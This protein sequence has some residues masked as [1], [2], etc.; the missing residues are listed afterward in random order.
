MKI[1]IPNL[2]RMFNDVL[3]FVKE[4][5]G[6]K[7]Y[8]D[9]QDE[10]ADGIKCFVF[11]DVSSQGEE[12]IVYGVR[13]AQTNGADDLQICYEPFVRTYRVE[14]AED[15]FKTADW[16]SVRWDSDVYYIPTIFNIAEYIEEYA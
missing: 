11:S 2:D 9:T 13:V 8:I 10:T 6:E 1:R 12:R 4:K 3:A 7:G 14:Y 5:Q 16:R 15:D